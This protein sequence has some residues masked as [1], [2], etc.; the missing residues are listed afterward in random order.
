LLLLIWPGLVAQADEISVWNFNDSDLMV[1]HG[2]GTLSTTF[3]PVNVLFA[4]GTTNNARLGD[5]AGQALSLQ[6]GTG[7]GNNGR[8]ITFNVS[9]L[10][11][12]GIIVSL[13]TQG[14]ATGFNLN[15]FQYSLDGLNFID[16]G[17]A[18]TPLVAFGATPIIFNLSSIAGLNNNPNAA[19]RIVFNGATSATGNNRID[20]LVVAGDPAEATVPEPTA[21]LLL[22]SGLTTLVSILRRKSVKNPEEQDSV[23]WRSSNYCQSPTNINGAQ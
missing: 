14:T 10:G 4:A 3:N 6:S 8:N 21:L 5:P 18:Y 7:N 9:T 11:F 13:A 20:N 15:Q 22:G 17:S 19:F 16:F 23:L 12:S 1:D 2:T